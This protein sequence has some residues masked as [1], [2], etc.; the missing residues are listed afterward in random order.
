AQGKP[1]RMVGVHTDITSMKQME[2]DLRAAK[3]VADR[4]SRA[5]TNFLA[6]MSHEIRTPMNV[7]IGISNILARK[8]D[9]APKDKEYIDALEISAKS[10]F[11]LINDLL[12]LSKLD[13]GSLTL[14]QLP[15]DVRTI[16]DEVVT[17][18]RVPADEKQITLST[19]MAPQLPPTF[20]GDPT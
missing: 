15:F 3:T 7:I 9:T 5:K 6:N 12:D 10:L 17:V 11:A 1:Y 16:I 8:K 14:E 2:E 20:I 4:A 18:N 19:H 13:E